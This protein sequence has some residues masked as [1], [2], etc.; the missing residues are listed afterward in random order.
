M[1]K[2][3]SLF[4]LPIINRANTFNHSRGLK[5]TIHQIKPEYDTNYLTDPANFDEIK[6]NITNR[7]GVGSIETVHDLVNQ[8]NETKGWNCLI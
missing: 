8:L 3:R 7:K 4:S 1:L 6:L 2:L 5:Q